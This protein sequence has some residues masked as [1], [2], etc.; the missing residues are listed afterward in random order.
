MPLMNASNWALFSLLLLAACDGG[1]PKAEATSAAREDDA[2]PATKNKV[3]SCSKPPAYCK[4]HL[5]AE[6]WSDVVSGGCTSGGATWA[7]SACSRDNVFGS[8][9]QTYDE[10]TTVAYFYKQPYMNEDFASLA[11]KEGKWEQLGT[12]TPSGAVA[13]NTPPT[14]AKASSPESA[15]TKPAGRPTQPASSPPPPPHAAANPFE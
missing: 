11:C 1:K 4:E 7:E 14:P 10:R 2:K 12:V 13:A 5:G 15:Q 8:C 6:A 3:W 9:T